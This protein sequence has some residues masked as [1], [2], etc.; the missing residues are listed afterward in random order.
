MGF[1]EERENGKGGAPYGT[2]SAPYGTGGN[3]PFETRGNA[4]NGRGNG[5]SG[6]GG[7]FFDAGTPAGGGSQGGGNVPSGPGNSFFEPSNTPPG[8]G[9]PPSGPGNAPPPGNSPFGAPYGQS[10]QPPGQGNQPGG[11]GNAPSGP[12]G[13]HSSPAGAHA[14]PGGA[15]AGPGSAGGD[16]SDAADGAAGEKGRRASRRGRKDKD[17]EQPAD[18]PERAPQSRMGWSPYDEG[19]TSR[20]PLWFA[21]GGIAVLGLLGGGLALMWNADDAVTAAATAD[22]RPTTAPLPSAPPGKYGFAASRSTDPDPITVKEVFGSK[23][24]LTVSGRSYEM[25]I[26][27]KDKKCNDGALGDALQKALKSGKCT[28]FVRASFRDKDGKVIGTVGVANLKTSKN[29]SSVAKAGDTKNYVKPL[30]GKDS[31]TKLLGSGSGGAKIWTHGHYAI[32]VWFQNKDGTKPDKKGSKRL[33]EAI[34]DITKATVFPA[35]DN[36]TL[37]GSPG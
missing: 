21:L 32:L 34:N 20:A 11:A 14:G 24:K 1:P 37:T 7:S 33:F 19:R 18:E 25:T 8:R 23:K 28:Q 5:H 15:P 13:A 36:R 29:A 26:T 12:R 31:V 22:P 16:A 9:N 35:L 27:S 17:K 10:N 6:A 2:G 30:A 3:S 4:S